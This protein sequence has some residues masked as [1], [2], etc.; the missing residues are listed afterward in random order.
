MDM[1]YCATDVFEI[2]EMSSCVAF[3]SNSFAAI[4]SL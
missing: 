4:A 1:L 3:E 2:V